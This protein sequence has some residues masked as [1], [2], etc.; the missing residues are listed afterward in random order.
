MLRE[1]N[2]ETM[3][4]TEALH[5]RYATKRMNGDKLSTTQI[6]PILDAI[7]L[8]PSSRGLQPYRIGVV[9]DA[10]L[11]SR[12]RPIADGQPQVE[13]CSHLLVF[14]AWSGISR[15]QIDE[16]I[17]FAAAERGI[18]EAKLEK[19]RGMLLKDQLQMDGKAFHEW[20]SNQ[21]F[22]ALGLALA[23]A[24]LHR[25]DTTPMEGFN[26]EAL[27]NLLGLPSMGLQSAVLLA[28]GFRDTEADWL[29]GLKKVRRPAEELFFPLIC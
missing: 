20:A 1:A 6:R 24:A 8:A 23:A 26:R 9:E 18:P 19:M 12:I 11:K 13:E 3:D 15:F 16:F 29:V 2:A 17:R 10:D 5:W 22:I 7:R 14:S 4:L 27:D 25:V 21:L 28:L